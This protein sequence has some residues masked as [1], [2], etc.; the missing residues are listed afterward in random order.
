MQEL[1]L[2]E[3][4]MDLL[5]SNNLERSALDISTTII[6]KKELIES[7]R[8]NRSLENLNYISDLQKDREDTNRT[9][10]REKL[11]FIISGCIILFLGMIM[12]YYKNKKVRINQQIKIHRQEKQI[13]ASELKNKE[14]EL[15]KMSSNIVSKNN[16]LNSIVKDLDY[17]MSLIDSKSDRKSLEPLKKRIIEKIDDSADWDQFQM[18]FSLAYPNFIEYLKG[19]YP[20]LRSGDVKL[21]CYLKMNMNTK[22]IARITSLSVRAIEN[23]RYRLRKKLNLKTDT[24]LDSFISFMGDV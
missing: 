3:K 21:C 23:K 1:D 7:A 10:A 20:R 12:I 16:L 14:N 18:Q 13:I 9:K 6:A 11:F 15:I 2:L 4:K 8:V 5:R 17:H 19:K 22:E 24:S